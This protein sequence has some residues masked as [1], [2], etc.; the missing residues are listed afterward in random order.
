[1]PFL[2]EFWHPT[3]NSTL[4]LSINAIIC[5]FFLKM[6]QAC[7]EIPREEYYQFTLNWMKEVYRVLKEYG[8]MY[9][10]SGWNNLKDIL[11]ALDDLN[12]ITVNHIIWK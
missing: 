9:V 3:S 5:L 10:F 1:M 4:P 2:N 11:M 6:N 12:F 7:N 8:S